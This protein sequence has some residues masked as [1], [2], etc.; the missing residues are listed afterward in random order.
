MPST[1]SGGFGV[2]VVGLKELSRDLRSADAQLRRDVRALHRE[3]SGRAV[4]E[5]QG[6]ARRLKG[7]SAFA[8]NIKPIG[9][10]SKAGIRYPR[11]AKGYTAPNTGAN[12]A[13]GWLMGSYGRPSRRG[14]STAQFEYPWKGNQHRG[15]TVGALVTQLLGA[16]L[17]KSGVSTGARMV[18][19]GD[20]A[21]IWPD[22]YAVTPALAE[23][24][25]SFGREYEDRLVKTLRRVDPN[26]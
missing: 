13:M 25:P 12:P 22:T 9:S 15:N 7:G 18:T 3:F 26:V 14:G 6:R 5:A 21:Q 4:R 16:A 8:Q 1:V 17:G 24:A 23:V 19:R 20:V 10:L 11:E 2:A